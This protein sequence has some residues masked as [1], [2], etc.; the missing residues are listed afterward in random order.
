MPEGPSNEALIKG[1]NIRKI[2]FEDL[3]EAPG[4]ER[5][6][7]ADT[8][9]VIANWIQDER[10][11]WIEQNDP[12][13][14]KE[15][16]PDRLSAV[17]V[18][19]AISSWLTAR[20]AASDEI[21]QA[22]LDY[23]E[24]RLEIL[25]KTDRDKHLA[26]IDYALEELRN[27]LA[28]DV[29]LNE[30]GIEATFRKVINSAKLWFTI[31][32]GYMPTGPGGSLDPQNAPTRRNTSMYFL[33]KIHAYDK[34]LP[35]Q[36]FKTICCFADKT[37]AEKLWINLYQVLVTF[38]PENSNA[39][40]M[41]SEQ[42]IARLYEIEKLNLIE[43]YAISPYYCT[44]PAVLCDPNRPDCAGYHIFQVDGFVQSRPIPKRYLSLWK[45]LYEGVR[46][47]KPDCL[48]TK[49][50]FKQIADLISQLS[51]HLMMSGDA[52]F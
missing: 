51:T 4:N 34:E 50:E 26:E 3:F 38:V 40:P 42:A 22:V 23:V 17:S 29:R 37:L 45:M 21:R 20:R 24:F 19:S 18:K 31:L 33:G 32:P 52:I 35:E 44:T 25:D 47:Q 27:Q 12:Q 49:V 46:D 39:K 16:E 30:L 11:G 2:L 7:L 6:P 13:R 41:S 1:E 8:A 43:T 10:I 28:E 48:A 15:A 9:T 14:Y 36:A 5:M